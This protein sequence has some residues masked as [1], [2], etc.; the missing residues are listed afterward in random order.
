MAV[1]K[2]HCGIMGLGA[3]TAFASQFVVP[4]VFLPK[5]STP[6]VG[7][8]EDGRGGVLPPQSKYGLSNYV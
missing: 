7:I 2:F 5:G 3:R 1:P 6:L 4:T 8:I